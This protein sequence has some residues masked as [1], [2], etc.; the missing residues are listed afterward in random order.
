MNSKWVCSRSLP[1]KA[2]TDQYKLKVIKIAFEVGI[3]NAARK[4]NLSHSMMPHRVK[5]EAKLN[6]CHPQSRK[7][8]NEQK[9]AF[10]QIVQE[11][12][13]KASGDRSRGQDCVE[14]AYA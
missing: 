4:F 7:S 2:Y 3:T 11:F 5:N 12:H 10:P 13:A 9:P 1:R 8:G 14:R 6:K